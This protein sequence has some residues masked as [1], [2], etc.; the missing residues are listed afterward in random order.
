[1]ATDIAKL[2]ILVEAKGG[3]EAKDELDK[4]TKS[5]KDL[6]KQEKE[7]AKTKGLLS[8]SLTEVA[9]GYYL[10]QQAVSTLLNGMGELYNV[11]KFEFES[12]KQLQAILQATTHSIGMT[13]D[14]ISDLAHEWRDLIGIDDDV[15][16]SAAKI[17]ATFT[18]LSNA[19]FPDAIEQALNMSTVFG[20]DLQQSMVQLGTALNDPI[21]GIGRLRRI[22]I[23]F[24][25]QQKN[26]IQTLMEANDVLGAQQVI[27]A[28]LE[29]E[30]GG[31][32]RAMGAGDIGVIEKFKTTWD[33]TY[34]EI[35]K[36]S[37][38][39][40]ASI[41]NETKLTEFVGKIEDYFGK[42]NAFEEV[43][44]KINNLFDEQT[45]TE[46]SV[47]TMRDAISQAR[48]ELSKEQS[49][50]EL[51]VLPHRPLP[52]TKLSE[53]QI[54][55]NE[56]YVKG[57]TERIKTLQILI[58]SEQYWYKSKS[59]NEERLLKLGEEA[60]ALIEAQAK[61]EA[62][63]QK[64]DKKAEYLKNLER[65]F[66]L[67]NRLMNVDKD[68]AELQEALI[69]LE[70]EEAKIREEAWSKYGVLREELAV[71]FDSYFEKR[72][73][74]LEEEYA[75]EKKLTLETEARKR[76]SDIDS[77]RGDAGQTESQKLQQAYVK[78]MQALREIK[79]EAL[80][81]FNKGGTVEDYLKTTTAIL[82]A[83]KALSEE[84]KKEMKEAFNTMSPMYDITNDY[85]NL[86][87]SSAATMSVELFRQMGEALGGFNDEGESFSI[88]MARMVADMTSAISTMFVTAGLQMIIKGTPESIALGV[89]LLAL[90]GVTGVYS[91]YLGSKVD[92]A[93]S[94]TKEEASKALPTDLTK[95]TTLPAGGSRSLGSTPPQVTIV[96]T[97]GQSSKVETVRNPNGGY[98]IKAIIGDITSS[99]AMAVKAGSG[100]AN[101]G[102]PVSTGH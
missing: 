65:E 75:L 46:T 12:Q 14:Q 41:L 54:K 37:V 84:Y 16:R 38:R 1:M 60:K 53:E 6:D 3:K 72:K 69:Q 10:A 49:A 13:F 20:Q 73:M 15:I 25:E 21:Q 83:Q 81:D 18:Q 27:I 79:K 78:N 62:D 47:R 7:S 92:E 35:A 58:D 22:G 52:F 95:D 8:S 39:M 34:G 93:T 68:D 55:D 82:E 29:R 85:L 86:L 97:T 56:N 17:G 44:P 59:E 19:V 88:T 87:Q 42:Q 11:Y 33:A 90:G 76:L 74:Q 26:Q 64:A 48:I 99:T 24:T 89:S 40:W 66:E 36:G 96:N 91:G 23:S 70:Y 2:M 45:L 100:L 101:R 50:L 5:T 28:E 71:A 32:A 94:T 9:A 67:K 61:A 31:V 57:I 98:D 30:I 102:T 4:V 63:K 51:Q 43:F 77:I 80:D